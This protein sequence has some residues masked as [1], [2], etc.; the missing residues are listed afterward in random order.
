[1]TLSLTDTFSCSAD[2]GRLA[3]A[4]RGTA[5]YTSTNWGATLTPERGTTNRWQC[6]SVSADGNK[7]LAGAGYDG[8]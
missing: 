6:V 3:V 5:I 8:I 4:G 2:G 7:I 1:M